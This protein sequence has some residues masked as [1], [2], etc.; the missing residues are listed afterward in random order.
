MDKIRTPDERFIDLVDWPFEPRYVNLDED[1]RVHYVDEGTGP[2][3]LHLHCAPTWG[4][5]SRNMIPALV[6]SGC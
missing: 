6:D 2:T 5:L 4:Y 1:L 3:V